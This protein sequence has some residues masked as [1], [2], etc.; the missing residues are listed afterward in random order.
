LFPAG[1]YDHIFDVDI[2][3]GMHRKLP[4]NNGSNVAEASDKFL[5]RENI[6]RDNCEAIMQFLRTN[7]LNYKTRDYDNS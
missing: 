4:F 2:G 6:G 5:A 3:D 1:E 7:A